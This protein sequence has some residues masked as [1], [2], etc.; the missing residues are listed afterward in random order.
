MEHDA[1]VAEI[2]RNFQRVRGHQLVVLALLLGPHEHGDLEGLGKGPSVNVGA[3]T[4]PK[5]AHPQAVGVRLEQ[6]PHLARVQLL[7]KEVLVSHQRVWQ[8]GS[9][10]LLSDL[11]QPV[12]A[13]SR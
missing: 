8:R 10:A 2:D 1:D 9:K 4:A 7:V 13:R 5:A 3:Q 11:L 12:P 6:V